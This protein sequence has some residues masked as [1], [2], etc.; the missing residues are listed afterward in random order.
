MLH[1]INIRRKDCARGRD[2]G[3]LLDVLVILSSGRGAKYASPTHA[4]VSLIRQSSEFEKGLQKLLGGV[5]GTSDK[6]NVT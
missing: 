4:A 6:L 1:T 2:D 3:E 5:K